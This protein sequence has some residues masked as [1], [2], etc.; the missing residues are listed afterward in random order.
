MTLHRR[1]SCL[2]CNRP[3]QPDEGY[4]TSVKFVNVCDT[5]LERS[6][7]TW[8]RTKAERIAALERIEAAA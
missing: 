8:M 4:R 2:G 3:C 7:P 5:C 6:R 1:P